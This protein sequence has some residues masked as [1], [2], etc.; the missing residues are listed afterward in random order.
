MSKK[1]T[2]FIRFSLAQRIEHIVLVLSFTLLGLTGLPQKYPLSPISQGVITALGGI[3]TVRVIHRVAATVFL[4]EAVYHLVVVGYKLFVRRERASMV[5]SIKDGKDA[6][7]AVKY[8]LGL[9][10]HEP[11]MPRYNFTEKMEYWAMLWG[12]LIMA[13]TGF[14]L[15]NPIMTTNLLPGEFVPAAKVAHGGEAVLAVLAIIIWHFYNVHLKKLNKSMF[16]GK[17]DR[18]MMEE[19][20]GEELEQI[21][22]GLHPQPPTAAQQR[23]RMTLYAPVASVFSVVLL[24]GVYWFVNA[25]KTSIT[26]IP[27]AEVGQILVTQTPTAAPPTPVPLPT[28]T[29]GA[30]EEGAPVVGWNGDLDGVFKE[31]CG[32]C[33]GNAGGFSAGSYSDVMKAVTPGD[34]AGSE[35]IKVQQVA[36][37]G[38]FTDAELSRVID[39]I[40]GGAPE[41]GSGEGGGA[42]SVPSSGPAAWDDQVAGIFVAQCTACHGQIGG[43]SAD[44]YADVMKQIKAGDPAA[45]AVIITQQKGNHP[46]KFNPQQLQVVMDWIQAGAPEK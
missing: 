9:S 28:A 19:E 24:A 22:A 31:K 6:L 39:W 25:E 1:I 30:A 27:P 4:L 23:S 8:N 42:A 45:S 15:W 3:E 33:H 16:T 20:H 46:G 11:K 37:P 40:S 44:T 26:T 35:L 5:P 41:Q 18:H 17:M 13:L 29:P 2:S 32:A 38:N 10:D 21:Q 43:F 36:H 12:F 34:P 7:D 14:M